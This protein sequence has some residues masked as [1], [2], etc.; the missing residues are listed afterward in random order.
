[1]VPG[2]PVPSSS[3]SYGAYPGYAPVVP[4]ELHPLLH[5]NSGEIRFDLSNFEFMPLDKHGRP[6]PYHILTQPATHPATT[7]MVIKLDGIPQWPIYLDYQA[8]TAG[9]AYSPSSLP[10]ITLG[11]VLHGIHQE[12]QTQ[13][14]HRDW[15]ELGE[16]EEVAI[17]KA[18]VRR[19]KHSY[20]HEAR[21]AA[22]GVKRVDYLLKEVMFNGL[23][24]KNG[25]QG[26]DHLKLMVKSK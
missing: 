25:D 17:A 13:I 1:M 10:P 8:A 20:G 14:T 18:Y 21:L 3:P 12:M 23:N 5:P 22:D 26:F 19:Y 7:R 4:A 2:T 24:R 16:R 9:K 6:I 11:D 15:A